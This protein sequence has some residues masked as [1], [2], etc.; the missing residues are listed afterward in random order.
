MSLKANFSQSLDVL[1]DM[2]QHPTF[3][4]EE[5][6]RSR[7]SRLGALSQ[8][9]ENAPAVA[10]RVELAALYGDVHR[11]GS[12]E[13]GNEAAV[14]ATGRA[15]LEG[16]WT[17]HY[18]PGNAALVVSGDITREALKALAETRFGEWKGAPGEQAALGPVQPTSARL[19]LVDK[20]GAPQ[21]AIRVATLG[22]DRKTPDFEALQVMNAALGGLFTSRIN[23]NLREE[24]G[25]TY[26]TKS[27]FDYRRAPGPFT[28]AGSIRTDVTGLAVA[29][30]FKE[31]RGMIR[32]PMGTAELAN[33]RNSQILSL[34]GR[35]ETNQAIGASLANIFIYDLG[36]DYYVGL[37]A[38]Y[39]AVTAKQAQAVAARYLQPTKM[40]VIGVGDKVSIA[41]Q[42]DALKLGPAE[43]RDTD[44]KLLK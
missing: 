14:K 21:T 44:G 17:Q 34:P 42:F 23:S 37:P 10:A 18:V 25:Y 9:R 5:I 8:E 22:T 20:P 39:A 12:T 13:L 31:L 15:D 43:L 24:K 6:E 4:A 30:I 7:S 40:I 11:Y 1:A 27:G 38:R 2:V 3:P 36:F 35:F 33:A 19:I 28:I 41:S 16:F 32:A 29:E 26:G